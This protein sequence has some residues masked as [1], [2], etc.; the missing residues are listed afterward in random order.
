M[1]NNEFVTDVN[2]LNLGEYEGV[3]YGTEY[4]DAATRKITPQPG[5]YD[6]QLPTEFK[7]KKGNAGQLVILMDPLTVV[8]SE[9]NGFEI[10]FTNVSTKKFKNAN[11]SQANDVLRNLG[12]Y[13]A[14]AKAKEWQEAFED[15]AGK[16][17]D[18]VD[19]I[20]EGYDKATQTTYNQKQFPKNEEGL[21]IPFVEVDDPEAEGGKRRVWANLRVNVRGFAVK[22]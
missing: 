7:F 15:L 16:V 12:S 17:A 3:D 6:L 2:E 1:A 11:A 10:R 19:C 21:L 20:W 4:Q 13:A 18:Q 5:K 22:K 8:G 14:P 9:G